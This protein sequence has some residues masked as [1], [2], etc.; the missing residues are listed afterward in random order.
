MCTLH[1]ITLWMVR[2]LQRKYQRIKCIEG[3]V[4]TKPTPSITYGQFL[5]RNILLISSITQSDLYPSDTLNSASWQ[6]PSS[7]WLQSSLSNHP[8][9]IKLS[10]SFDHQQC[11]KLSVSFDCINPLLH[12]ISLGCVQNTF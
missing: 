1:I 8:Q 2:Y 4:I 9:S 3:F 11:I 10:V 6:D 5:F 12:L 7:Q